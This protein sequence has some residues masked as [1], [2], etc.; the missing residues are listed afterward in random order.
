VLF[1][2]GRDDWPTSEQVLDLVRGLGP[3]GLDPCDGPGSV[4]RARTSFCRETDGLG[5]DW[6]GHGLVFVNF[7]YSQAREWAAKIAEE[8][9]RGAEI[10]ALCPV[11]TDARWWQDHARA[12]DVLF[13]WR[14]RLRF[15]GAPSSAPFPSA[16]WYAGPRIDRFVEIFA[17]HGHVMLRLADAARM[18]PGRARP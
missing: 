5:Q 17:P 10:V 9:R 1:S 11:R 14:G 13:F 3:I 7:P 4:T 8:A 6:G 18:R 15:G 16:L 2:H 12:M